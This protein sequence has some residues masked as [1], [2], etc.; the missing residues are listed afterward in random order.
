MARKLWSDLSHWERL[1]K[2]KEDF[3][4]NSTTSSYVVLL[5]LKASARERERETVITS[6]NHIWIKLNV[7]VCSFQVIYRIDKD[8]EQHLDRHINAITK[9]ELIVYGIM[10]HSFC[11][12][13]LKINCR[14]CRFIQFI[15]QYWFKIVHRH[16]F[17]RENG[18][19]TPRQK[20]LNNFRNPR[21]VLIVS[22]AWTLDNHID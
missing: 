5:A 15:V 12:V 4:A 7:S 11:F 2:S 19:K 13:C 22:M 9:Q 6:S 10:R 16:L 18:K 3:P 21:Q 20:Q 8:R 14:L 17:K 1:L